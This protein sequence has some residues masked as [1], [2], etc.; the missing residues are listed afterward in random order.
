MYTLF[1]K[2]TKHQELHHGNNLA[3]EDYISLIIGGHQILTCPAKCVNGAQVSDH[4]RLS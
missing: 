4:G 2:K 1:K 3:K